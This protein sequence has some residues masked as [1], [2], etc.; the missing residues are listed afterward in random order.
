MKS[1]AHLLIAA[2]ALTAL[3][4]AGCAEKD[5]VSSPPPAEKPAA[6]ADATRETA[7]ATDPATPST[8]SRW[9][10]VKGYPF[11]QRDLLLDALKPLVAHVDA[12]IGDLQASRT[13][14][15]KNNINTADWDFAMKEMIESRAYLIGLAEELT[16][17]RSEN[18]A[19]QKDKFGRGW[20]RTQEA[21]AKVRSST[22]S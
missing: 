12:Q 21:Y 3:S 16:K 2:F 6:T 10:N 22:T 5:H 20:L 8:L 15:V 11:E 7:S 14:M 9:S 19:V 13:V 18:W 4:T 17:A 1:L